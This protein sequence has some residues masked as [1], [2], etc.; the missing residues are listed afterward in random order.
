M[1][2]E[3]LM[4]DETFFADDALIAKVSGMVL[5]VL[6][7]LNRCGEGTLT[8]LTSVWLLLVMDKLDMRFQLKC[9]SERLITEHANMRPNFRMH[10]GVVLL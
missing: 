5:H 1:L 4:G 7:E 10:T 9:L 3:R 6:I 8:V 2:G